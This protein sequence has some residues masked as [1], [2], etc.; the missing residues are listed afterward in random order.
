MKTPER[1]YALRREQGLSQAEFA[2]KLYVT[3]QAVS[4]WENGETTPEV[5]T[6]GRIA[7]TFGVTVDY[8]LGQP[9]Q[10]Q[11][12]G[13]MLMDDEVRGTEA[14]GSP[15]EEYCA[16]CYQQGHFTEDLSVEEMIEHNLKDLAAWNA[17]MGLD[18]GPEEAR[19]Q[20][21]GFLPTLKRWRQS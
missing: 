3:R 10:C 5:E 2:A 14:D 4:R 18:I 7:E 15:S 11:S 16:F 8:L 19:A 1:I 12:C 21:A 17:E 9:P 20:L 13:E 6:L